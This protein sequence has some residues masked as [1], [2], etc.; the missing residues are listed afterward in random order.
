MGRII[1]NK[2][3][4]AESSNNLRDPAA[5]H[6]VRE[7]GLEPARPEWTLYNLPLATAIGIVPGGE[8]GGPQLAAVDEV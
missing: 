2:R 7:A 1:K 8:E 6:L 4:T 3:N 5:L